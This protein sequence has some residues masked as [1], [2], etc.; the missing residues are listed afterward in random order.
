[1]TI[2]EINVTDDINYGDVFAKYKIENFIFTVIL[3]FQYNEM[4]ILLSISV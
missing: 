2:C 3:R 4:K 1:M